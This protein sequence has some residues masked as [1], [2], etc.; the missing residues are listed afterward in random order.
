M[1]SPTADEA[2]VVIFRVTRNAP[3]DVYALFPEMDGGRRFCMAYQHVGQHSTADYF[4]CIQSSRPAKAQQ[5]A[6]LK[7]ELE[8]IG[9]KLKIRKRYMRRRSR[10]A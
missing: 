2:V 10:S 7:R 8:R 4:G 5:Y 6:P 3:D 9:Y 1:S